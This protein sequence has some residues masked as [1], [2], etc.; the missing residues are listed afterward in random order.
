[1]QCRL[2]RS[3]PPAEPVCAPIPKPTPT[4]SRL[5][6]LSSGP[7]TAGRTTSTTTSVSTPRAR[8]SVPALR[9]FHSHT[10]PSMISYWLL[11]VAIQH[12]PYILYLI[13]FRSSTTPSEH[14]APRPGLTAGTASAV[15]L[16]LYPSFFRSIILIYHTEG[17]N[18]PAR[19]D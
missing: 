17:G 2:R 13:L 8:I 19:L 18:F 5:T 15:R 3:L 14:S 9:Y 16:P 6:H 4:H 12:T 1:M 7:S 10:S 11:T